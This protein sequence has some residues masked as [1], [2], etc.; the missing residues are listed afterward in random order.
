MNR[1]QAWLSVPAVLLLSTAAGCGHAEDKSSRCAAGWT[2]GH[3][4]H[5]IRSSETD[6][7][8]DT[9][10]P[11]NE[12]LEPSQSTIEPEH[13]AG[14][15][16]PTDCS[17]PV[18]LATNPI[19]ETG[20]LQLSSGHL[21]QLLEL[22]I[23]PERSLLWG[24][25]Q[26]GLNAFDISDPTSPEHLG[27]YPEHGESRYHHLH[28][29]PSGDP[30]EGM[31]YVTHREIGLTVIDI[32]DPTDMSI[33]WEGCFQDLAGMTQIDDVLYV[34]NQI[35]GVHVFDISD[36]RSPTMVS[37]VHGL[38][39][40]MGIAATE[41]A[42]YVA[43]PTIGIITYDRSD[44]LVLE[45]VD[46]ME[47]PGAH[48]LRVNDSIILAAHGTT[49][50]SLISKSD[51]LS[52]EVL[53]QL[54][55]GTPVQGV[56]I[57]DEMAWVAD[58]EGVRAINIE[59]PIKPE[60]LGMLPTPE[61][62]MDVIT[63]GEH[64]WVADWSRISS[65]S[66]DP[67][68]KAPHA[69]LNHDQV[70]IDAEGGEIHIQVRN[71]GN[72]TLNLA[73]ATTSHDDLQVFFS[74]DMVGPRGSETL[75]L[76]WPGGD[77]PDGDLCIATD[78]P[79]QP[80]LHLPVHTGGGGRHPEIGEM[81]PDFVLNAIAIEGTFDPE[82]GTVELTRR[83][84]DERGHPV[85]LSFTSIHEAICPH[86]L[87]DIE[88]GLYQPYRDAGLRV[89]AVTNDVAWAV[90]AAW[91]TYGL[92]FDVLYDPDDDVKIQYIMDPAFD[93]TIYP[94]HWLIGADGR[95]IYAS[96]TYDPDQLIAL[97]ERELE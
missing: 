45:Q 37:A 18:E 46:V 94:Q 92:S 17:P 93:S 50:V 83:L 34:A 63:H 86:I 22:A 96:N 44:P 11:N 38:A 31:A 9:A 12:H 56:A 6:T 4:G 80:V 10:E 97:I 91:Q 52:P 29:L 62:A 41:D 85:L 54:E 70:L 65:Y 89:W 3:D 33:V 71:D 78:D 13:P 27:T 39:N 2:M 76:R 8:T 84:A 51:P 23:E 32:E 87:S 66:V 47:L 28:L 64:A 26:G 61:W 48:D 14:K 1:P 53:T 79:D 16:L 60:L 19:S 42:V 73:G 90:T 20:T 68:R 40:P 36:R 59:V 67:E 82:L 5:C 75:K 74:S 43:D 95:I 88:H 49:G 69:A 55:F 77:L 57:S 58:M 30:G 35:G 25:G 7:A 21:S 72:A 15:V 24:V 81:A